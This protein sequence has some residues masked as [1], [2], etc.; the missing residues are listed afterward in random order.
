MDERFSFGS[1][2]QFW[3]MSQEQCAF[4]RAH[5][6]GVY[7]QD[8]PCELCVLA[9]SAD[10]DNTSAI[11][12]TRESYWSFYDLMP[13]GTAAEEADDACLFWLRR[14]LQAAQLRCAPC[15]AYSVASFDNPGTSSFRMPNLHLSGLMEY[16]NTGDINIARIAFEA[17]WDIANNWAAIDL[18]CVT[19]AGM[20][21]MAAI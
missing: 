5:L 1:D 3:E 16:S 4:L 13:P 20:I 8:V 12:F 19:S 15:K 7:E 14:L 9:R 21:C 17:L 18:F 6:T 11:F 10:C 2:N